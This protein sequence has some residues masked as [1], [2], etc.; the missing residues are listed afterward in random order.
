[1]QIQITIPDDGL[2]QTFD[3]IKDVLVEALEDNDVR[4]DPDD[5]VDMQA[6][7]NP[8]DLEDAPLPPPGAGNAPQ[9]PGGP[10]SA[11]KPM[12]AAGPTQGI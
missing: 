8:N 5:I 10:T 1:M 2:D 6:T 12:S 9:G 11:T 4:I 7:G 3:E